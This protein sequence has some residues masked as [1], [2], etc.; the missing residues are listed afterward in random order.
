MWSKYNVEL[1]ENDFIKPTWKLMLGL[2]ILEHCQVYWSLLRQMWQLLQS[3][4]WIVQWNDFSII[5]STPSSFLHY[6]FCCFIMMA[7]WTLIQLGLSGVSTITQA[8]LES[9]YIY[10]LWYPSPLLSQEQNITVLVRCYQ[11]EDM[12]SMACLKHLS[13]STSV[14]SGQEKNSWH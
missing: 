6:G 3:F 1:N 10:F 9:S 12:I 4:S 14:I 13:V 8:D 7:S 5:S 2:K 11:E